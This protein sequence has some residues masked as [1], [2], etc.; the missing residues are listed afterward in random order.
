MDERVRGG[1][2][3]ISAPRDRSD[4]D[5]DDELFSMHKEPRFFDL[6]IPLVVKV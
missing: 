6:E 3:R 1:N 2:E 5:D 4:D